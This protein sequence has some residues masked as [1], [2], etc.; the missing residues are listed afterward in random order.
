MTDSSVR[1]PEISTKHDGRD[2]DTDLV[3]TGAG[4][5]YRQRIS[6]AESVLPTG[7]AT[8]VNQQTDALTDAQLRASA[9]PVDIGKEAF[10]QSLPT[11]TEPHLFIHKGEMFRYRDSITI[12]SGVS[13]DYLITSPVTPWPH[14]NMIADGTALTSFVMYEDTDKIGT[15]LQTAFNANRNSANTPLMTIH[16]GTTGGTTDGTQ[17]FIYSSGTS[18]GSSKSPADVEFAGEWILKSNTKYIIRITSGTAA[19]LCNISL[20]WYEHVYGT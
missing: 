19:N 15:T 5:V 7:A 11:I 9:L 17:L 1:V 4:L 12:G 14:L 20:E 3:T 2:M 10:S 8:A 16:K 13:Q 6:V 18:V